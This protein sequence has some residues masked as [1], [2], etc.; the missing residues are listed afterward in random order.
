MLRYTVTK[1]STIMGYVSHVKYY[2]RE[3]GCLPEVYTTAFLKQI[4]RGLENTF[5]QQAD[6]RGAF[7]LPFYIGIDSFLLETGK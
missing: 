4:R 6:K 7:F 1:A 3:N 5:P 2:F